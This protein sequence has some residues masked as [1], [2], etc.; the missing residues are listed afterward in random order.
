MGKTLLLNT[1]AA[2]H[3]AASL[4]AD[5]LARAKISPPPPEDSGLIKG[6]A[7][8]D[9][10]A[11]IVTVRLRDF[12]K[13]DGRDS[14][15]TKQEISVADAAAWAVAD[16]IGLL[17]ALPRATPQELSAELFGSSDAP[18]P[19]ALW[20]LDGFD[21]APGAEKLAKGL[22]VP[23][24][25]AFQD[26]RSGNLSAP[27]NALAEVAFRSQ[28]ATTIDAGDRLQAVL[29]VLLTEA[30]VVVSSRPQFEALLAPFTGRSNASYLRLDL[31]SPDAVQTFVCNALKVRGYRCGP[32]TT[33]L[34]VWL[35]VTPDIPLAG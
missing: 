12:A 34:L 27:C 14:P 6:A 26:A 15:F 28:I 31:L 24:K 21:E 30:N 7:L 35:R 9:T 8:R 20:L 29:R 25:A 10:Y 22:T 16:L 18:A 17:A 3:A 5:E 32:V 23:V 13:L 19:C 11:R 2:C 33:F 4:P 1:V